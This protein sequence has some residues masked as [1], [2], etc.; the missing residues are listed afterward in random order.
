MSNLIYD[1]FIYPLEF[2]MEAV[3]GKALALTGSPLFS[4][5][6]VSIVVSLGSLPLYHIAETWQD[7]ER[8]IQKKL[9]P[10]IAEL[11][12]AYKGATLNSYINTLY[13]QNKY[14]PIFAV[15]TS[16]G[17]LIQIPFFF[18]AY[19]L[20]SNYTA[21]NGVETFLFKDLGK[22]DSLLSFAGITINIM[23]FVMTAINLV[24]ATIYGKKT[25][26]KEN[27][28]LYGMALF[29]LVVLYN[30]S[31]ALLF[32]WTANNLFSLIKNLVYNKIY[33]NGIIVKKDNGKEKPVSKLSS[34]LNKLFS[35]IPE[36]SAETNSI[37]RTALFSFC[38]LSFVAAPLTILSSGSASDF[39]GSLFHYLSYIVLFLTI[40]FSI[41]LTLFLS[42]PG[43]LKTTMTILV[44]FALLYGLINVFGFT[45]DYGDM[46]HFIFND[47]IEI[48][49]SDIQL[50]VL[51]GIIAF[52]LT[53]VVF[54]KFSRLFKKT[55]ILILISL[56]IFSLN[57]ARVFSSIMEDVNA[58]GVGDNF[59]TLSKKGKNVI[60]LMLDR[61]IGG[62]VPQIL[63]LLPELNNDLE[64]FVYYQNSLSP[65]SYT[66]GGVPAIMGGWD[67]TVRNANTTRQDIPLIK[68]LDESARILPYNFNKAGFDV[69]IISNDIYGWFEKDNRENIGSSVYIEPD[70]PKFREKWLEKHEKENK[71]DGDSI[72]K[73]LLF[74]GLFRTAPV[75]LRESI[76]D[77]GEWHVNDEIEKI[78]TK[79]EEETKDEKKFIYFHQ[80][81]KHR[82]DTTL[83]YYAALEFLPD[84]SKVTN[85]SQNRFF[86]M[87]NDLT[88][89]P[90]VVNRDF[91]YEITGKIGYPRDLY[92]KFNKNLNSL[93]H[94]YTDAAAIRLVNEWFKWM[95]KNDVYDNTRIIIVSDHG[96]AMYDPFFKNQKIPGARKKG[97]PTD[98]DNLLLVK[99]FNSKGPLKFESEFMSSADVPALAL[100]GIIEGINPYTGNKIEVPENK[101]PYYV[102][103]IQWRVVK[104]EKYKYKI[105]EGYVIEKDDV[106]NPAKWRV[107][108]E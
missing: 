32:Y 103:D 70:F 54:L 55:L 40:I 82:K 88:H 39:E 14:H 93:K 95:K 35:F 69:T 27:L 56:I 50:N 107:V 42:V 44:S 23:P 2:I 85:D 19:H 96:R 78:S 18:A 31:S 68:K 71:D 75:F 91:E 37:F 26:L 15:R 16:F 34:R 67:Y 52:C 30:S 108:Y 3:L 87:T 81:S 11:K 5:I 38:I 12:S 53:V 6:C 79:K 10:K 102:Y 72:R 22:P 25:S 106:A 57:E 61:F 77:N 4:L 66:I 74:F 89:E 21:F 59:F 20:L 60:I 28:Q 41:I 99:D 84:L 83:K 76:Y 86:Y 24:S 43:K 8:E 45:G 64:G 1:I 49:S 80:K 98:F 13:R 97:H 101:F 47:G 7:R 100:D 36:S 33:D 48:E 65:A 94:L 104:Q 9:K 58:S 17:L 90:H 92:K 46:S 62:F 105:H 63:E 51:S 29:F 73:K